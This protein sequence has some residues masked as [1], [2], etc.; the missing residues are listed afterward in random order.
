MLVSH[1]WVHILQ[2][3]M[4]IPSWQCLNLLQCNTMKACTYNYMHDRTKI[5]WHKFTRSAFQIAY[6]QGVFSHRNDYWDLI[7]NLE[8]NLLAWKRIE[9][10]TT[11]KWIKNHCKKSCNKK[12]NRKNT[13]CPI[14]VSPP[15]QELWAL[16]PMRT[17]WRK[18]GIVYLLIAF[19]KTFLHSHDGSGAMSSVSHCNLARLPPCICVHVTLTI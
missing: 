16:W 17:R 7:T 5:W 4:P 18:I 3:D 6:F 9:V 11:L 1:C 12:L 13:C 10:E 15:W 2:R 19:K 14:S 8:L